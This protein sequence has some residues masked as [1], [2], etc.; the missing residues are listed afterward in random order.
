MWQVENIT[1]AWQV[2]KGLS[3]QHTH[4]PLQV[5]EHMPTV[6]NK[7]KYHLHVVTS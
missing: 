4:P 5:S 2:Q 1:C 6:K 7:T 3:K